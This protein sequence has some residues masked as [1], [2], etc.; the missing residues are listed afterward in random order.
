MNQQ[1]SYIGKTKFVESKEK[2]T[3]LSNT[4][5][6]TSESQDMPD[7]LELTRIMLG[8]VSSKNARSMTL[9]ERHAFYNLASDL[10]SLT[11]IRN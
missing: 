6:E 2:N 11:Q 3:K 4:V 10:I 8:I 7:V 9:L 5:L 1:T